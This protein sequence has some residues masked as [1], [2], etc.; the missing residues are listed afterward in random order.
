M[1]QLITRLWNWMRGF[2]F[3]SGLA[4]LVARMWFKAIPQWEINKWW[5][6]PIKRVCLFTGQQQFDS[7][8]SKKSIWGAGPTCGLFEDRAL[9][10]L[11]LYQY[12]HCPFSDVVVGNPRCQTFTEKNVSSVVGSICIPWNPMKSNYMT[13]ITFSIITYM[14]GKSPSSSSQKKSQLATFDAPS[15][16]IGFH[17]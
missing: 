6:L 5:H 10:K 9:A 12:G 3:F 15:F 17:R 1:I 8:N 2:L 4:I 11:M 13:N 14:A 7:D 16:S